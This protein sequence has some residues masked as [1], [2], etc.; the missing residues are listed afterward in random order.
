MIGCEISTYIDQ[1]LQRTIWMR[2]AVTQESKDLSVFVAVKV[3]VA[4]SVN[5][6]VTAAFFEFFSQMLLW[7]MLHY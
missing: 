2:H 6:T 7:Y 5:V 4:V 3:G 1:V